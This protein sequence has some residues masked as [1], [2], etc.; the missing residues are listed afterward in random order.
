MPHLRGNL[1]S[2]F[3]NMWQCVWFVEK[4]LTSRTISSTRKVLSAFAWPYLTIVFFLLYSTTHTKLDWKSLISTPVASLLIDG[5]F[6]I[7]S[8]SIRII[9]I[10]YVCRVYK[11]TKDDVRYS[12]AKAKIIGNQPFVVRA[13]ESFWDPNNS[14]LF[15][16]F[17]VR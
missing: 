15:R 17:W 4:S 12:R 7:F 3:T 16:S 1:G 9:V 8:I 6:L 2:Y 11:E 13:D 10:T 5:G 14:G